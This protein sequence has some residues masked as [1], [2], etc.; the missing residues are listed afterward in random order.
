MKKHYGLIGHPLGH[1]LSPYIHRQIMKEC[2]IDGTYQAYDVPPDLLEKKM[3]SFAKRLDGFNV[4]IPYKETIL[5]YLQG[6]DQETQIYGAVNTVCS[7]R[8]YNTDAFG[9]RACR[10][11]LERR[12]V[13][14]LGAGGAARVMLYEALCEKA[15]RITICS[16]RVEQANQLIAET[17]QYYPDAD[18]CFCAK[19]ELGHDYDV[20][21]NATP[22]GMWPHCDGIPVSKEVLL[23]AEYVFDAIYNP[24]ASRLVLAARSYR[25]KA[26]S[27]L[28]MLFFQALEAQKIWNPE[29]DFTQ[30][31]VLIQQYKLKRKLFMTFPIKIVLT[32]F[33]G[34]GKTTVGSALAKALRIDFI[35]LDVQIIEKKQKSI[36]QIFEEEGEPVFRRLEREFLTEALQEGKAKVIATGGGALIDPENVE[37]VRKK[38]GFIIFLATD[39]E[40][41]LSRVGDAAD[42]PLL[43][44]AARERAIEL[45]EQR[46]PVYQSV[47]DFTAEADGPVSDVVAQIRGAFDL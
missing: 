33:M 30:L 38:Q 8:G 12:S 26:Q 6:T 14:L 10:V 22:T 16:R 37:L 19:E 44:G 32:G 36:V 28:S 29:T 47:A 20:V 34:C 43:K 17:R 45:Y 9:F 5:M 24:P 4:T 11:P 39:I 27:G 2:H 3:L 18:L 21:L 40:N 13:L 42:R 1:T 41:I 7:G 25:I 15:G 35:D 31:S 46:M 23:G